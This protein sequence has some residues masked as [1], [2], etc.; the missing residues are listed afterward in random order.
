LSPHAFKA[1][2][3]G[4]GKVEDLPFSVGDASGDDESNHRIGVNRDSAIES[5]VVAWIPVRGFRSGGLD[6]RNGREVR[7]GGV[8][9]DQI[10]RP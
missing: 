4:Y 7:V 9:D 2:L 5:E 10:R 8:S 1:S 6:R 3:R